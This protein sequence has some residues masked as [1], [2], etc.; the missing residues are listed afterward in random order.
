MNQNLALR[1]IGEVMGWEEARCREELNWL[2]TISR[3][4]YDGYRGF[5]AGARFVENLVFWLQQFAA[6][7]RDQAY[8]YVRTRLVYFSTNQIEHLVRSFQPEFVQERLMTEVSKELN[9]P[10]YLVWAT[11]KAADRYSELL[12]QT[13]FFGLSD[14]ARMDVFRRANAGVIS[15]EQVVVG[16]EINEKKWASLSKDLRKACGNDAKF[17]FLYL[18]DDFTASGTTLLRK[19]EGEWKGKL[20][21]FFDQHRPRFSEHLSANWILCVHHHVGTEQA[22]STLIERL[23]AVKEEIPGWFENIELTFGMTLTEQCKTTDGDE[24]TM[25]LIDKYYNPDIENDHN[26]AGGTKD[27]RLGYA[28]CGLNLIL[29]HNTPNNS[30]PLLWESCPAREQ[31]CEMRPLFERR[32]RHV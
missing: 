7:D 28:N 19:Q 23:E 13:L 9:I 17:S 21:K 3:F 14:G 31:F 8:E 22:Q 12:R 24:K 15:N 18:V 11:Q 16:A 2:Q 4:R 30:L 1:V 5:V 25:R 6:S 26:E 29:E 10:R 20:K 32:Q 27:I